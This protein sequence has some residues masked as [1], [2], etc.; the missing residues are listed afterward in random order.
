MDA[1]YPY[2]NDRGADFYRAI[3]EYGLES[4]PAG[5]LLPQ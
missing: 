3:I 1:L 2:Y 4:V 5:E